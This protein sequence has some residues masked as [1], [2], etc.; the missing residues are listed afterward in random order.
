VDSN[1]I[2]GRPGSAA[3]RILIAPDKFKGSLTAGEVAEAIARG[4]RHVDRDLYLDCCP[5]ADGGEGTLDAARSAGYQLKQVTV[6]GPTGDPV[7][8]EY[9]WLRDEALIELAQAAGL[10]LLNNRL[11]PLRAST[12]GVG[13][14]V[15]D[16]IDEGKRTIVL[17]IGGSASSD[18]GAGLVQAL[19]A[20]LLDADGRT[21]ERGGQALARI[22]RIDL[23]KMR[24]RLDGITFVVASDVTNPLL[25]LY[26]AAT[27]FGPQKG[28]TAED[29]ETLERSLARWASVVAKA[30]GVDARNYQG[31]GAA[32]GVGFGAIALLGATFKP[33]ADKVFEMVKFSDRLEKA[34]LVVTGEGLLDKQTL[35]GKTPVRVANAARAAGVPTVAVVGKCMVSESDLIAVGIRRVYSLQT[36]EPDRLQSMARASYLLER[37]GEQV[38]TVE[39]VP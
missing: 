19:G 1:P 5:V 9:G 3:A 2:T 26:G 14:L 32:G 18:G 34:S 38:A 33:G 28:A 20:D 36:L 24:A 13:Q 6:E 10:R 23:S 35:F 29:V 8:A 25:G 37:M 4:M 15:N 30:T 27:V 39:L 31:A 7:R 12:F 11:A 22:D 16:A 21:L 17:A